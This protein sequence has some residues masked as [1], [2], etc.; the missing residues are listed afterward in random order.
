MTDTPNAAPAPQ[1]EA[2]PEAA[3]ADLP[4]VGGTYYRVGGRLVPEAKFAAD[5]P[6]PTA[7]PAADRD[8]PK[9]D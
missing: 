6:T 1:G 7:V 9:E 8:P 5:F 3:P 2:M 4:K